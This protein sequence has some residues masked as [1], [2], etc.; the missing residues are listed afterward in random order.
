M[1]GEIAFYHN[2][3]PL[4]YLEEGGAGLLAV[5]TKNFGMQRHNCT[6][7][8]C[9]TKTRIQQRS[10]DNGE[11]SGTAGKPML[12]VLKKTGITNVVSRS[13]ALFWRYQTR[14]RWFGF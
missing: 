9:R 8:V 5:S 1:C 6:A 13:N 7:L 3:M 14:R 11:P 10:S 2:Y 12:E 4:F